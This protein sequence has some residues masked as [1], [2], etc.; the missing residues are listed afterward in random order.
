MGPFLMRTYKN[1]YSQ[2][3]SFENLYKAYLKARKSKR[4]KEYVLDFSW[5]V[6]KELRKLQEELINKTYQHGNYYKFTLYDAKKREIKAA[7]FRDRVVHHAICAIIE[8][9]FDKSFVF[10]SYACRKGKGTH[11]AIRRLDRFIKSLCTKWGEENVYCLKCDI[12]KYFDSIDHNILLSLIGKKIKDPDLYWLIK[13]VVKSSLTHR[14]YKS[15]FDFRDTG[16]PIG[17]LTSQL[18][19]NLYLNKLDQFVKHNLR[20]KYYLRYMDD[21]LV[22]SNSK[23][24]L[25]RLES[26]LRVFLRKELKLEL[27]H[28][29]VSLY[30]LSKGIG[31][32]GYRNYRN[33]RLVRSS[34][35]RR[36]VRNV[37]LKKTRLEKEESIRSWFSFVSYANTFH[38]KQAINS[39]P[40]FPNL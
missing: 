4:Y 13:K 28:T 20:Q 10:D 17:N 26:V 25:H 36:F 16:I 7:P 38:L 2:V 12:S 1:L 30:T 37:E 35:V 11:S 39:R 27:H 8:P 5:D 33:Y 21:F 40:G 19:A 3:C 34:T 22:L 6:E 23:K 18:F 9:I 14:V 24:E 31:F 29:K 32:L 15:L